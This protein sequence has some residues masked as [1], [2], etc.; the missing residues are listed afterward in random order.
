MKACF[1]TITCGADK[2]LEVTLDLLGKY[3][4]AGVEIEAGRIDDYLK[5][6]SL[7]DLKRQ[8]ARNRLQ[9]AAIMAFPFFAFDLNQQEEQLRRVDQ[10]ARI[11]RQLGS[12]TLLCFTADIPPPGMGIAE[13]IE[14][15]GKSAQRYGEVS[16]QHNVKCALEPIGGTP[17]MPGPRQALA[18]AAA[19]TSRH[20]GIMM[21][22]FH[23]YKSGV[24]L[25]EIRRLPREQL[26]IVHVNDC[27]D[28]PREQLND[29]HRVY[30]GHGV[31]PLVEEFRI[32]KNEVG[33]KGFLSI[34]IFNRDYWAD[35]HE[36]VIRNAKVALDAVLA[37]V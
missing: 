13:A 28:L 31:I 21:D 37:K 30:P 2:P 22:T 24:P 20:V 4:Y 16:A 3:G 26:L 11:A 23:Y 17:F 9:V 8:L 25:E 14:R 27:I 35:S 29:S 34:E 15:A 12:Q 18:V 1:N 32:L 36:N 6:H 19:S 5:R 7:S 10:Y 33:Y